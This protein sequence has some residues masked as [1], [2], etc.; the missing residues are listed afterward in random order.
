[1]PKIYICFPIPSYKDNLGN[2]KETT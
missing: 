2:A 1:V